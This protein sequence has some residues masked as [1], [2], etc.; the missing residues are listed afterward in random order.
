MTT[1]DE[2]HDFYRRPGRMTA[3]PPGVLENLARDIPALCETVQGLLLHEHWSPAYGETLLPARRAESQIRPVKELLA[4]AA[5]HDPS[6]L[7][8]PR[9]AG[10][11][12]VGVCR[13]FTLVAVAA[14]RARGV[15]ARARCGFATYFERGAFIDHWVAEYWQGDELRWVLVDAQLD[16]VHKSRIK[17]DFDSLDVPRDRFIIAGDAWRLWRSGE[18]DHRKFGIMDFRGAW[19][20]ANNVLRDFAALNN[21]EMLPWDMWGPMAR[22]DGRLDLPLF[23]RLTELTLDADRRFAESRA[24]YEADA[25]LRVPATVFNARL[26]RYDPV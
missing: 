9:P 16:E 21:M 1:H 6:P 10:R 7:T 23:D 12:V 15:P 22:E 25:Q 2:I 13:H 4:H 3:S 11:R 24:L 18:E 5:E 14:L 20:I 26:N 19:F 17:P 8:T